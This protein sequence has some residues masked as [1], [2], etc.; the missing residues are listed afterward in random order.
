MDIYTVEPSLSPAYAVSLKLTP[1]LKQAL[2]RASAQEQRISL[3]L[4]DEDVSM[5]HSV[6]YVA[7]IVVLLSLLALSIAE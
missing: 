7:L 2:K 3:R 5:Q 1:D 4:G 6:A